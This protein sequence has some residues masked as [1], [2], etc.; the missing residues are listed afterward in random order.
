M[1]TQVE[2]HRAHA[3]FKS[4]KPILLDPRSDHH[5]H[6]TKYNPRCP[7]PYPLDLEE[8]SIRSTQPF[9]STFDGSLDPK[10]YI[11]WESDLDQYFE[12][13]EMSEERKFKFAKMKLVR[14]ARLF[15]GN[16]ERL[17]H[18][19]GDRP[20]VTWRA[21]K[22]KLREKYLSFSYEQRLLDQWQR[23]NQGNKTVSEYITKFDEYVMRCNIVESEAVTLSRFRA[24]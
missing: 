24:A 6:A 2:A 5:D 22:I 3:Q 7:Y 8:R 19:R 4:P 1:E 21:M 16:V 18:Q 20:I 14:Q 15:W 17:Y 13:Y 12:W 10:M 11:D 23:L 9:A